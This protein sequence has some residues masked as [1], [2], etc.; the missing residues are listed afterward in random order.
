MHCIENLTCASSNEAAG[1]QLPPLPQGSDL[2]PEATVLK[3]Q[4]W[5]TPVRLVAA[6]MHRGLRA[7]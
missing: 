5:K 4:T 6:V 1:I 3:L 7:L 2:L